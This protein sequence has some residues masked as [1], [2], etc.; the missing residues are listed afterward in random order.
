MLIKH[1]FS[2]IP[3][4]L[5]VA[6]SPTKWVL[7]SIEI[8]LLSFFYEKQLQKAQIIIGLNGGTCAFQQ[9]RNESDFDHY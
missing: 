3:N 9:M 4:H 6:A 1:I 7:R 2:S 5:L 8:V